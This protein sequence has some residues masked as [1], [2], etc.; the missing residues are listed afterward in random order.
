MII[1]YPKHLID[2][3]FRWHI[4]PLLKTLDQKGNGFLQN[5]LTLCDTAD[6]ADLIVI[7]MSWNY[8]YT[9]KRVTEV[10]NFLK[11][12][13]RNDRSL[14]SFVTGDAG[15]RVPKDYKGYILRAS[16]DRH[17]LSRQHLGLPIF[18]EDPLEKFYNSQA[19]LK[20][21][22]TDKPVVGFC[23]QANPLGF[24]TFKAIFRTGIK[25]CLSKMGFIHTDPQKLISTSYFRS[26]ILK[27][28]DA[29]I[30][31]QTNFV[32]RDQYRAGIKS[33]K[34]VHETTLAFYKN[35]RESD[36]VVCMRGAGNFSNRFYETLAMGRIPVFVNTN[37]ILP[38][39]DMVSW[40][41][42]VV[43]VEYKEREKIAEKIISFHSQLNEQKMN[44]LFENNRRL[45]ET[46]LTLK[47][48]FNSLFNED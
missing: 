32:I 12:V 26:K 42:H 8:Y 37:C 48:Y 39:E 13:E 21:S 30:G 20:R 2:N 22:Y 46:R 17:K 29:D 44:A 7:P 16:G 1:Y 43:W 47:P 23:G 27:R 45:W 28:L 5:N 31:I 35:I 10:L 33:D 38:L 6:E 40:K 24:E 19:I 14:Y 36:Y 3:N 15:N 25:N 41:N 11:A 18:V 4:F 34:D 9:T